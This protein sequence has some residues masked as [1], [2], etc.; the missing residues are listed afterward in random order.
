MLCTLNISLDARY[1]TWKEV[2]RIQDI[3]Y[4]IQN[5]NIGYHIQLWNLREVHDRVPY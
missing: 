4:T 1:R 2:Y 3:G 5:T